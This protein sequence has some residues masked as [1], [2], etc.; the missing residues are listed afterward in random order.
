MS[1]HILDF[2]ERVGSAKPWIGDRH[3]RFQS[4]FEHLISGGILTNQP[5]YL[6]FR[7]LLVNEELTTTMSVG[8]GH[9]I[10]GQSDDGKC[11]CGKPLLASYCIAKRY[12]HY[13]LDD[14]DFKRGLQ[15]ILYKRNSKFE[16]LNCL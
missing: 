6:K 11:V 2:T 14:E 13:L 8:L 3:S 15:N 1:Q 7:C 4:Y 5:K 16:T 12:Y 10:Q 9:T